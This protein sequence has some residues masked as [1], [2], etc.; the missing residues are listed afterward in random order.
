MVERACGRSPR[1]S[2]SAMLPPAADQRELV[3]IALVGDRHH[4]GRDGQP[5]LDVVGARE[6]GE[7][8]AERVGEGGA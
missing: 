4:F 5:F 1:A 8:A 7:P 2:A 3:M 6:R